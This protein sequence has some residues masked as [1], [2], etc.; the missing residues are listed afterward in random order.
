MNTATD[1]NG[2]QSGQRLFILAAFIYSAGVVAFSGWFYLRQ[3]SDL[4]AQADQSLINA[5]YAIEQVL[6]GISL[7]CAVEM[8]TVHETGYAAN[9]V[10]LDNLADNCRF[11]ALG[12]VVRK[13]AES[14]IL[15]AGGKKNGLIA[16]DGIQFQA[17]L[18]PELSAVVLELAESGDNGLRLL[19]AQI[20]AYGEQRIAIRY[21]ARSARTGYA[22]VAT[23][24]TRGITLLLRALALRTLFASI[25]LYAMAIPLIALYNRAQAKTARELA[26]LNTR[27]Q[28]DF[29]QQK[30]RE[31]ELEDAIGDLERFNAIALGR[32]DRIVELKAEVNTLLEQMKRKKRYT[33]TPE[34]KPFPNQSKDG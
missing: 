14:W 33:T 26:D 24:S 8:E 28:Q 16:P 5:T 15:I 25:F 21:H 11:D 34:E 29:D 10:K 12:A 6:G 27:L 30:I 22:L 23:R 32:E 17:P 19:T 31:A 13:G 20:G 2:K 4:Y 1:R 3:R 18:Q 9:R 7:E